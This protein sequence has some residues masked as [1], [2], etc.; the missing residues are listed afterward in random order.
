MINNVCYGFGQ[1]VSGTLAVPGPVTLKDDSSSEGA[2]LLPFAP[3]RHLGLGEIFAELSKGSHPG[4]SHSEHSK[5]QIPSSF[6]YAAFSLQG[7]TVDFL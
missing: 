4:L 5:R 3:Q 7:G 2:G 1:R 6:Q